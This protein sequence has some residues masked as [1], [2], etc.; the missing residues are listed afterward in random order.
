MS[1]LNSTNFT[2]QSPNT[3]PQSMPKQPTP[4]VCEQ[5]PRIDVG[6]DKQETHLSNSYNNHL[7]TAIVHP[8]S[9]SVEICN[10]ISTEDSSVGLYLGE[11]L[12]FGIFNHIPNHKYITMRCQLER[13]SDFD[14]SALRYDISAE[15]KRQECSAR[16][17]STSR[18][19]GYRSNEW[20]KVV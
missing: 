19:L 15:R 11:L 14:E 10:G 8:R 2:I 1:V 18:N 4:P 7:V 9:L 3:I 12:L 17:G 20:N 13:W 6:H 5:S 16:A